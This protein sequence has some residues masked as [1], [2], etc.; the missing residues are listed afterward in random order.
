MT[1]PCEKIIREALLRVDIAFV[2]EV[3]NP[4]HLDFY[5][6]ELDVHIEVKRFH[7]PRIAAQMARADNVI[8]VQ[9]MV[10]VKLLAKLI[11]GWA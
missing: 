4:A 11:G 7:S 5:L 9:G 2:E 8:A 10:A 3:D 6:S 1:C